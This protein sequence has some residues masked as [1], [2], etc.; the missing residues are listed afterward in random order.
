[1][2]K[3]KDFRKPKGLTSEQQEELEASLHKASQEGRVPCASALAI[4]KSQGI[5]AADIGKTVDKLNIRIK[6]YLLGCF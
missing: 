1:M 6:K 2:L 3:I 5:P 4:A